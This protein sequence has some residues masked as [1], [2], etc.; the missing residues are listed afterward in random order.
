MPEKV[1]D[2]LL[3]RAE[4]AVEALPTV[5]DGFFIMDDRGTGTVDVVKA[6]GSI[7]HLTTNK[8]ISNVLRGHRNATHGFGKGNKS[9]DL[10]ATRVL[11]HHD[12]TL[13]A[14][15]VYLPYLYLLAVMC[16][17]EKIRKRIE[18][19]CRTVNRR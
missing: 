18:G 19:Q 9:D 3:P 11:A 10:L 4:S 8:A 1:R 13:P 15:L 17:P 2:V 7:E 16:D 5:A 6:D 12:G 14:E